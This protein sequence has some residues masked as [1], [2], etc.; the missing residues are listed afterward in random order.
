MVAVGEGDPGVVVATLRQALEALGR[1]SNERAS[2][3]EALKVSQSACICSQEPLAVR[4]AAQNLKCLFMRIPWKKP[5]RWAAHFRDLG[6]HLLSSTMI[7][8]L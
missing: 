7:K 5:S 8:V 2:L 6:R 4:G 3:E 1:L